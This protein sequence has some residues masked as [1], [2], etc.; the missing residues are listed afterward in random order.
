[1]F[2]CLKKA[3][4]QLSDASSSFPAFKTRFPALQV[5]QGHVTRNQPPSLESHKSQQNIE[6]LFSSS[7]TDFMH[8]PFTLEASTALDL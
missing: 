5:D 4:R 3:S 1:M 8:K 2:I 7:D 6:N